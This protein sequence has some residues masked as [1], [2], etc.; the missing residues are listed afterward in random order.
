MKIYR[1]QT[2]QNLALS[3]I[4]AK[5]AHPWIW[6]WFVVVV[7]W[8]FNRWGKSIRALLAFINKYG[9]PTN[10]W[11][12]L[13][14]TLLEV[15]MTKIALWILSVQMI[16][17]PKVRLKLL[18]LSIKSYRL[19]KATMIIMK[20]TPAI[21][22]ATISISLNRVPDKDKSKPIIGYLICL[23]TIRKSVNV[24]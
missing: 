11:T 3:K 1:G 4:L 23:T 24:Y 18:M 17:Q 21:V 9:V 20:I 8:I 15:S 12:R 10:Q 2:P 22:T 14:E 13:Y 19:Q 16:G 6:P 5:R 7:L